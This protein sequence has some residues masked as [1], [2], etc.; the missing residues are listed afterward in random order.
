MFLEGYYFRTAQTTVLVHRDK[1][2]KMRLKSASF[3]F[4]K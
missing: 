1:S 3:F 4:V 2:E